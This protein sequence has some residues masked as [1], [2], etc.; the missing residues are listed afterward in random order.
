M[1]V[2]YLRAKGVV[3]E[4]M[5]DLTEQ[6]VVA[7]KARPWK[8]KHLGPCPG[9]LERGVVTKDLVSLYSQKLVPGNRETERR[10]MQL[11]PIGILCLHCGY[12]RVDL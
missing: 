1:A 8:S 2:Q 9:E 3:T 6:T 10:R 7:L 12:R 5:I 11:A 4:E